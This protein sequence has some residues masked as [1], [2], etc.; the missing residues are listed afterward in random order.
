MIKVMAF[1]KRKPGISH[2]EF[3]QHYEE[4]HAPL[5]VKHLTTISR[6][7]RPRISSILRL[8]RLYTMTKTPLWTETKW[9][10]FSLMRG[11]SSKPF[12]YYRTHITTTFW[13]ISSITLVGILQ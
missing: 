13:L 6:Y 3:V 8:G 7:V 2:E 5:A 10:R 9:L 12:I 4:V 11:N 1:I